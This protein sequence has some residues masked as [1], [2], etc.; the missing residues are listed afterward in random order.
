MGAIPTFSPRMFEALNLTDA[1]KQQMEAIK[2]ELEPEFEEKLDSYVKGIRMLRDKSSAEYIRL[3][4]EGTGDHTWEEQQNASLAAKKKALTED[5][6]L[7]KYWEEMMSQN[8]AFATQFRI[9]MFD[10]LNDEQWTRFQK[11][12]DDPSEYI[13][14]LQK[15]VKEMMGESEKT[16]GWMPGPNSWRPGDPIPV[17]YRQERQERTRQRPGF[18][19][20]EPPSVEPSK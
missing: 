3:L 7:K 4:R 8:Q 1:Q 2:N 11:L 15:K 12:T 14:A 17:E 20:S 16:D 9:K 13:K 5:M 10:V 18:P 19:R 6:E